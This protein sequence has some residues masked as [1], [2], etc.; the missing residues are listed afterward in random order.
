MNGLLGFYGL[1]TR[2]ALPPKL[3]EFPD[4]GTL[5]D[6]FVG[7]WPLD[8][9]QMEG[10]VVGIEY[11]NYQGEVSTR[12]VRIVWLRQRDDVLYMRGHCFLRDTLRT[13]R[14]DRI[15]ALGVAPDGRRVADP[16]HWLVHYSGHS[17]KPL[18]R[19]FPEER[20]RE[21]ETIINFGSMARDAFQ[22][23]RSQLIILAWLMQS[24]GEVV[25]SERQCFLDYIRSALPDQPTEVHALVYDLASALYPTARMM[26]TAAGR[27]E[28]GN[29][30]EGLAPWIRAM[31]KADGRIRAEEIEAL[32]MITERVER[33]R[34]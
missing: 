7:D 13:F 9:D 6:E 8:P 1:G 20:R 30:L 32:R 29:L 3:S 25:D 5:D 14:V 16:R 11:A 24:D 19:Q 22:S 27:I 31:I 26:A 33:K 17:I 2:D 23:I 4:R 34:A 15:L 12:R 10:V 28:T 21:S 18:D